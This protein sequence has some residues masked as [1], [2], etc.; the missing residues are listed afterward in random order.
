MAGQRLPQVGRLL[1][2]ED[3]TLTYPIGGEGLV[4]GES[5]L[6]RWDAADGN[7]PFTLEYTTDSGISWN[8]ITNSAS[9]SANYYNW[10]VPN[11]I[12]NQ[13]RVR[14]SRSSFSDE[15]VSNFT[16]VEVPNHIVN[17]FPLTLSVIFL[18]S[19]DILS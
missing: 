7:T 19:F 5:E 13:A 18:I 1:T 2:G 15:S 8:T 4:P 6:I 10:Q 11:T 3:I 16:I 9:V 17:N 12:T 14:I